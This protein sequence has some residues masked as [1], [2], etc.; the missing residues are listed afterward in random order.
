MV[1]GTFF[2]PPANFWAGLGKSSRAPAAMTSSPPGALQ[3]HRP[4][5]DRP[6]GLP[7][8]PAVALQPPGQ[9]RC[10]ALIHRDD[11]ILVA[12]RLVAP[13]S[14]LRGEI[15]GPPARSLRLG[16]LGIGA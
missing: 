2:S 11:P 9:L 8:G 16:D 10:P 14:G 7:P 1:S 4:A 6:D 15:A 13:L 5:P 3:D 12:G